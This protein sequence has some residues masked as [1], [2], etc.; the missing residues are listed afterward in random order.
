[1]FE[2]FRFIYSQC[3]H[4]PQALVGSVSEWSFVRPPCDELE[5]EVQD[6]SSGLVL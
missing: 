2:E 6:Q 1:V 3:Y 4:R 5:R